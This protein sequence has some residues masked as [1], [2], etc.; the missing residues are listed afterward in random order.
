LNIFKAGSRPQ[1]K[2]SSDWFHGN[3]LQTLI[4]EAPEPARIRALKVLFEPKA[5][6]AWHSHP[7]GQT[8]FVLTG[9][10]LIGL[11]NEVPQIIN[12][13]DTIWIPPD[14]EHWHGANEDSSM[15]HIAFQEELNGKV[16]D[17]LEH[18][19]DDDYYLKS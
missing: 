6:T 17:W 4:I 8:L 10:G 9:V 14:Q 18:V 11:R 3:V 19:I 5:R 15:E 1:K 16:A 13:G 12:A 2:P 7:L